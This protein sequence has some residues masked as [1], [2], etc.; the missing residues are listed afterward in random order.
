[1]TSQLY[2]RLSAL[3]VL[4]GY[5]R[6]VNTWYARHGNVMFGVW[7]LWRHNSVLYGCIPMGQPAANRWPTGG[8]KAPGR[9][10]PVQLWRHK[11]TAGDRDHLQRDFKRNCRGDFSQT[12]QGRAITR[13]ASFVAFNKAYSTDVKKRV[14]CQVKSSRFFENTNWQY[15][16]AYNIVVSSPANLKPHRGTTTAPRDDCKLGW[17]GAALSV[18]RVR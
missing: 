15:A 11:D 4:S 10:T 16:V 2:R 1:M 6:V 14:H 13:Y 3:S 9:R 8:R 7:R 12:R 17:R 5:C 18:L